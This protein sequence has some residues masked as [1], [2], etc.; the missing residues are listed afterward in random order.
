MLVITR[1]RGEK[2][3]IGQDIEVMVTRIVD[4]NVRLAIKAPPNVAIVRNELQPKEVAKCTTLST[5][6]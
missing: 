6:G 3:R 5:P 2:V 1:R 4:G